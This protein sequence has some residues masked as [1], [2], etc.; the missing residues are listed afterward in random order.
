M[1]AS[2]IL[3]N[4]GHAQVSGTTGRGGEMR[5][6]ISGDV[7]IATSKSLLGSILEASGDLGCNIILDLR[8]VDFIDSVGLQ[9]L[10]RLQSR[11][12]AHERI[13]LVVTGENKRVWRILDISGIGRL[14]NVRF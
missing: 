10:L 5:F 2:V 7:D 11:S 12:I 6:I 9:M 13:M 3:A 8:D 4:T 1:E 14:L